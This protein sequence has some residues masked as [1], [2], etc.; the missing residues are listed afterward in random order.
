MEESAL[1][2][3]GLIIGFSIAAPVGPIGLLCIRRTLANGWLAGLLSG[4]GAATADALYGSI[5]AFSL[6]AV[7]SLLVSLQFWLR[8]A[9]GLF[10]AWLGIR[11]SMSKPAVFEKD[12]IEKSRWRLISAYAST[13][14][15][16][17]SNPLTIIAFVGVFAGL[18]L[19]QEATTY[20]SGAWMVLGV[21]LGSTAWWLTL[22]GGMSY[23][24]KKI[25]PGVQIWVNRIS[26][27]MILGFGLSALWSVAAGSD[28][29][30]QSSLETERLAFAPQVDTTGFLRASPEGRLVFPE[31]F[32]P[33]LDYQT[34]WWYFTG[35]LADGAGRR[36]GYQLTFFRRALLAPD[37]RRNR[38]SNWGADQVYLAHFALT[39]VSSGRH[40]SIERL[41]RGAAGVAGAQ[42]SPFEVWL[43]D[44]TV[45]ETSQGEFQLAAAAT[46]EN[47][48][49][50]RLDLGLRDVK[51]PVLQ[52]VSG[53]SQKG[54][55]PG[56]ASYYYSR[57]RME[58]RGQ[59]ELGNS[60]FQ[61]T[62]YSWMDHE[63]STSALAPG[64][65]GWDWFSIQLDDQTELMVFQI[66]RQDGSID[67]F[68]S[69]AWIME[70]GSTI[71]LT[72]EDFNI[73]VLEEWKSPASGGTYPSRWIIT[74]PRLEIALELQPLVPDQE[75]DLT[76]RYWEGAVSIRGSRAGNPVDGFGFVEMTGYAGSMAGEF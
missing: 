56:N 28:R 8:L 13:F 41:A 36:F 12:R 71:P 4:L 25:N 63:F 7:S 62:G 46:L 5:A 76:Y 60:R 24:S 61:V 26:G 44:W 74:V 34:E 53:Y 16:T 72:Q 15:L 55:D 30:I 11:I 10:L 33:H 49:L 22:S 68:S 29:S 70:D 35:N 66:R 2:L 21:F 31:D 50:L 19:A 40:V 42:A 54:P 23:F 38:E 18:G 67:P 1:F 9:G 6:I 75:M 45:S 73:Q 17:L 47:G 43:D 14:F 37:A 59:V 57:P 64:Q 65:V 27:L 39:E 58:T 20:R 69:G 51:G 52:G 3:R 32:G 48:D